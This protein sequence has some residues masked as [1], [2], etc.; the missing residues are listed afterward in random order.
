MKP[1]PLIS[2]EDPDWLRLRTE[3]WPNCSSS[4]HL[5]EMRSFLTEPTRF[6][7][8]IVRVPDLGAVGFAEASIRSDYVAGTNSSPVGFLEGL[9]VVPTARRRGVARSLVQAAAAWAL[10][11][12]CSE[13]ASDTQLENTLSQAAHRALGFS[14]TERIVCFNMAL[15]PSDA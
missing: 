8:F 7:Q 14:E 1:E 12:G 13:L 2:A 3:L 10:R 15:S 5:E 6:A 9:Y 4:E 11:M